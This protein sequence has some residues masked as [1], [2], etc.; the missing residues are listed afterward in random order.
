METKVTN[1]RS[2]EKSIE[3]K[4]PYS[5]IEEE[6]SAFYEEYHREVKI[7]G[8]RK[9]KAP[10]SLIKKMFGKTIEGYLIDRLINKYFREVIQ[11]ENIKPI[12][13]AKVQNVKYNKDEGLS[14][15]AIVEVEPPFEL[16]GLQ[17]IKINKEIK[18]ITEK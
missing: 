6:E 9:G 1:I 11:K 14:F 15:I 13:E 10:P 17:G 18:K 8:F 16:A 5:E 4:I 12:S 7:E 2:C 3:I